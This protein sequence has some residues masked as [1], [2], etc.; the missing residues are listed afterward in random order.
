MMEFWARRP[1]AVN[2]I[3][4]GLL[5]VATVVLAWIGSQAVA[6]LARIDPVI[7]PAWL[8]PA[9]Y[10][11][12]C[13]ATLLVSRLYDQMPPSW[14]GLGWHRWM[15]RELALGVAIGCGMA[16]LAWAPIALM[17]SVER[18]ELWSAA[19]IGYLLI[20]M[21]IRAAGEE[22]LFRGYLF[23]RGVE[24][25]GPVA[26]TLL[27]SGAFAAA[28]LGN[29]NVT[30]LG[31]VIIFLGGIFF[32]LAY[33]RTG[34]LWLPIG[35]HVAWN[36]LLAKVLGVTVSGEAGAFGESLL[37]TFM[38]G[39][40]ILTGGSFGPEGGVI[41]ALALAA[42]IAALLALPAVDFSPYV[43]AEVFKAFYRQ[44]RGAGG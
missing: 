18:G 6:L 14:S 31:V 44:R 16:L 3:G 1:I 36:V 11:A 33:L 20:P 37:H 9:F 12:L 25:I 24:I 2:L 8:A 26:A 5:I 32:S 17:G 7:E 10:I 19:D 34:S 40:E 4:S 29:P 27:A 42:G 15:P 21:V 28:H 35:A 23:Q 43:H 22:L 39:P 13:A 30:T 38:R 41:G